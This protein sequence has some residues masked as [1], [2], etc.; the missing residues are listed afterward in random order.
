MAKDADVIVEACVRGW[1]TGSV[2]A[3]KRSRRLIKNYLHSISLSVRTGRTAI[4]PVV[5]GAIVEQAVNYLD[6]R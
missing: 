4:V 3:T 1:W 5:S 6:R 2:S